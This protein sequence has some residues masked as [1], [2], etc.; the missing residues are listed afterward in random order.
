MPRCPESDYLAPLRYRAAYAGKGAGPSLGNRFKIIS[1]RCLRPGAILSSGLTSLCCSG[2]FVRSWKLPSLSRMCCQSRIMR[3]SPSC[4]NNQLRFLKGSSLPR[5]LGAKD[6]PSSLTS[7]GGAVFAS[8]QGHTRT[9][10][11]SGVSIG[12]LNNDIYEHSRWQTLFGLIKW[13][14]ARNLRT[15]VQQNTLTLFWLLDI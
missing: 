10:E 12:A 15:G 8:F 1:S 2:S 3:K 11:V 7:F 6:R 13:R 5:R 4:E 14:S 9:P